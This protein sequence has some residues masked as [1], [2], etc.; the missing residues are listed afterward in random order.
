ML[1]S[2]SGAWWFVGGLPA[3]LT[4]QLQPKN[5]RKKRLGH[6]RLPN[7]VKTSRLQSLRLQTGTCQQPRRTPLC[8][9]SNWPLAS[10]AFLASSSHLCCS[11]QLLHISN[12]HQQKQTA[13][14]AVVCLVSFDSCTFRCRSARGSHCQ[15]PRG[16]P[17]RSDRS[18]RDH[19]FY[20]SV[21]RRPR[22]A[23]QGTFFLFL[24][25][26]KANQKPPH[27]AAPHLSRQ[28]L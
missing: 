18:S 1:V 8:R 5:R 21:R 23:P 14:L 17:I 10:S 22:T 27:P 25:R 2:G 13:S 9:V 12:R 6:A 3:Q 19:L 20:F 24:Y 26:D 16:A 28:P 7:I 11:S 15:F 4:A